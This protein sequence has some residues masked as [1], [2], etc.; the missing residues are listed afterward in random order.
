M[1]G[2]ALRR[3]GYSASVDLEAQTVTDDDGWSASFEI[4]PFRKE[5]LLKGLDEIGQ[6]L[7]KED[8]IAGFE[9][10]HPARW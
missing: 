5:S 2:K 9:S 8:L 6:T 3:T 1:M 7:G 10:T 4:E